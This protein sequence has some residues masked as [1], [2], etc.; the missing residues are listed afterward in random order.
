MSAW[1][2]AR[3][4]SDRLEYSPVGHLL[5]IHAEAEGLRR[6]IWEVAEGHGVDI[7]ICRASLGDMDVPALRLLLRDMREAVG[8]PGR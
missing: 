3:D 5:E 2:P 1:V 6:K 7:R 4:G 8:L